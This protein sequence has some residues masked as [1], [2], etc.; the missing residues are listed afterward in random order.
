MCPSVFKYI[1]VM[2]CKEMLMLWCTTKQ[3][4][5][6][7]FQW[8][9]KEKVYFCGGKRLSFS[10]QSGEEAGGNSTGSIHM[11]MS[12]VNNIMSTKSF[13][14]RPHALQQNTLVTLEWGTDGVCGVTLFTYFTL[15]KY[16]QDRC[17][18]RVQELLLN[19]MMD[20]KHFSGFWLVSLIKL[21]QAK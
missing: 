21:F 18:C 2:L 4:S 1:K 9:L 17:H 19:M 11:S 3:L 7:A 13:P 10:I 5:L 8:D 14:L 12:S 15:N 16:L 6:A 20:K